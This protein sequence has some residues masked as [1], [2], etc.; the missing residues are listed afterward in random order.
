MIA[1]NIIKGFH[2]LILSWKEC[3]RLNHMYWWGEQ[4]LC[5]IR[6]SRNRDYIVNLFIPYQGEYNLIYVP[7][8]SVAHVYIRRLSKRIFH[9]SCTLR[10]HSGVPKVPSFNGCFVLFVITAQCE[11]DYGRQSTP[12]FSFSDCVRSVH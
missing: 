9:I 12:N 8:I 4:L 11:R 10:F 7:R 6:N 1:W 3:I 2:L 5:T